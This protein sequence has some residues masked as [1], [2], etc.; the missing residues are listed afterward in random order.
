MH[1]SA[2]WL[3][4]GTHL[5]PRSAAARSR[6]TCD[7]ACNCAACWANTSAAATSRWR[8]VR[9]MS[10]SGQNPVYSEQLARYLLPVQPLLLLP[11]RLRLDGQR[12]RRPRDQPRDADGL[13]RLLAIAVAAFLDATQR[14]VDLLQKLSFAVA[15]AKLE[16]VLFLDRRLVGRIGFEL[17]LAQVLGGEVGLL[18]QLLLRLAQTFAEERELFRT[19]VLRR[20]RAHELGFGQAVPL[21]RLL[22]HRYRVDHLF[23]RRL[24]RFRRRLLYCFSTKHCSSPLMNSSCGKFFP[25]KTIVLE[26]FSS[27]PQGRPTSPPMSMC[28]P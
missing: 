9:F 8:R 6:W 5:P 24:R 3:T 1:S 20:R 22:F 16:R 23:L 25:I 19:H 11:A 10:G 2:G 4:G 15:G 14:F 27:L 13:A 7:R 17:V 28:T 18:Q 21:D 12:R 26:R